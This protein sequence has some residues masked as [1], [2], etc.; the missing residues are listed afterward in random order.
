MAKLILRPIEKNHQLAQLLQDSGQNIKFRVTQLG[1]EITGEKIVISRELA[2]K[3]LRLDQLEPQDAT[4]QWRS[5]IL[6][7]EGKLL[8]ANDEAI[9]LADDEE[10]GQWT[11]VRV[12]RD[13]KEFGEDWANRMGVSQAKLYDEALHFYV[14]QFKE[15]QLSDS[16]LQLEQQV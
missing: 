1:L 9:I 16:E 3:A 15:G 14:K 8:Q 2:N 13:T 7:R 11:S 10:K 5:L 4:V 6:N 12:R